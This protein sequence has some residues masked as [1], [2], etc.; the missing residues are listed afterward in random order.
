[1]S[2]VSKRFPKVGGSHLTSGASTSS[3]RF[4]DPEKCTSSRRGGVGK[5]A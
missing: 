5:R 4:S 1:M 3:G 2:R